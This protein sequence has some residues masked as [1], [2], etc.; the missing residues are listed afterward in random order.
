MHGRAL[1]HQGRERP[2]HV[3]LQADV[4]QIE[5]ERQPREARSATAS[6][7]AT[8]AARRPRWWRARR[9]A[10]SSAAGRA[11]DVHRLEHPETRAQRRADIRNLPID[12][13]GGGHVRLGDVADVAH[14]PDPE[15]DRARG[16]LAA[17]RRRRERAAAATS[18]RS[19]RDVEEQLGEGATSRSGTTPS[20]SASTRSARPRRAACCSSALAAAIGIFLLLQA[21]VP[22]LAA[23][24]RCRS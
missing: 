4:P 1:G 15:R 6:S 8:S 5:V 10:T 12:T 11:Y 24:D 14:R 3:E 9:S 2:A 7:R 16:R 17:H 22:Q 23:G 13:P 20:C 18:A 19:S 21:C